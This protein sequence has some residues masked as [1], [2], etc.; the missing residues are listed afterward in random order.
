[1]ADQKKPPL[2]KILFTV[3]FVFALLFTAT[4]GFLPYPCAFIVK[5]IPIVSLSI[6]AFIAIRGTRGRII[7]IGLLFSAAGDLLLELDGIRYFVPGLGAFLV[8]HLFYIAAFA[9]KL[10]FS[11]RRSLSC[12]AIILYGLVIAY[13]LYPTL[14]EMLIPVAVYLF[15]ILAMGLSAVLGRVN[16]PW[17]VAG[18]LC[19][20]VSDSILAVNRFWIPVV[21]S[22][23]WIMSTYYAA[24]FMIV[25]GAAKDPDPNV[26]SPIE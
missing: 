14:G 10:I 18:T 25:Y 2:T 8:A 23:F 24:Q 12:G 16:S 7:G 22:G 3:F 4:L 6:L 26:S 9:K 1:M 20:L 13:L 5:T 21:F 17:V 15:V 19:F 11:T